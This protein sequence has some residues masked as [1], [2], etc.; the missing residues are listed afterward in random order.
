MSGD[1]AVHEPSSLGAVVGLVRQSLDV[2]REIEV[3][4]PEEL[5]E[6]MLRRLATGD[7]SDSIAVF[8]ILRSRHETRAHLRS[9]LRELWA[10]SRSDRAVQGVADAMREV[11]RDAG[12]DELAEPAL[13]LIEESMRASGTEGGW[14]YWSFASVAMLIRRLDVLERL[15]EHAAASG[16]DLDDFVSFF[17]D[18]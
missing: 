15:V 18:R 5:V 17:S 8:M 9:H 12:T 4:D 2:V 1:H 14:D 11:A 6:E 16:E 3:A 7:V 13:A 10:L